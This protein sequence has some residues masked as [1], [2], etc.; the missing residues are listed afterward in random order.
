M[1]QTERDIYPERIGDFINDVMRPSESL[2]RIFLESGFELRVDAQP[3]A[4]LVDVGTV[5]AALNA[6]TKLRLH[7]AMDK[8]VEKT[9]EIKVW[10]GSVDTPIEV[11][12]VTVQGQADPAC[13][14]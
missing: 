9:G 12:D 14:Q 13:R 7:G 6:L 1:S 11:V 10:Q 3:K 4:E 2:A 5:C 8:L